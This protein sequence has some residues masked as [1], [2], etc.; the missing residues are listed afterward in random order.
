MTVNGLL[1]LYGTLL[2]PLPSHYDLSA[3]PTLYSLSL[4]LSLASPSPGNL[5]PLFLFLFYI[6]IFTFSL[7][8]GQDNNITN[9]T[10]QTRQYTLYCA[11]NHVNRAVFIVA[12]W[13]NFTDAQNG[14][15]GISS[16]MS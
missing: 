8:L 11:W 14:E 13:M 3:G 6:S 5:L 2:D 1:C 9:L 15:E 10:T 4:S 7:P 16:K 12:T